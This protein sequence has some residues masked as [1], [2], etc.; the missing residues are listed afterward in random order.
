MPASNKQR[1]NGGT[2]ERAVLLGVLR[3]QTTREAAARAA[4]VTTDHLD[5]ARDALLAAQLPPASLTLKS[6]VERPVRIVRDGTG[7]PHIYAET[8]RDLFVGYGFALAQDRLWQIDYYRRRALGRLAEILGPSAVASD[9]RHRLLGLGRLAD[10]EIPTLSEEAATALDGFTAGINAW[11][12]HLTAIGSQLPVE[13]EIL[14]YTPEPWAVRDSIALMRAFFWQ[15][16]GRL[17]NIA[18]GEAANRFLG[19]DLGADFLTTEAADETI[20]PSGAGRLVGAGTGGA[21]TAGGSNNWAVSASRSASGS[22]MLA[23]D[24]HL[25]YM[26]PAGLYQVHLSGAGYDATGSGYPGTPGIWFGHNDRIAWG[27]TNL[28]ASPRD[29]YVE[30]LNPDD[31]TQYRDGD[32]WT[33]LAS[34]TETISVKDAAEETITIRETVRG[35]LVDEIVPLAPEAGPNGEPTALSV[36]WTGQEIVGDVQALLDMNRA[37]DWASFRAA[38]SGWRLPIFNLVYADVDGHIGWQATGSIPIRGT[39]DLSRGYRPA[40]DP[41]HAW[42]GYIPFDDLPRLEDPARGWVGTANNRPVAV[43]EQT[44]PL[45]GWWAPGHRAA[46]L[47]QLLDDGRTLSADDMRAMHADTGNGRAAEVLPKLP[48]LIGGGA[49]GAR[50]LGLLDGWSR[51]MSADSVAATVFEAFFEGWQR[52]VIAARL[53]AEVQP[54]L[55][56]LGAGSGLA[57][58][59]L[60]QGTPADWFGQS[61]S[62]AAVAEETAAQTLADL[63]A[64]FGADTAG[65]RWGAVHQVSFV[66]PLDGRP[67]TDGLFS[68]A[69]REVAGTGYVLNANS[70]S[71]DEP[72]DVVSG[73]EY[74]LVVDLGDLDATT[75]VLTT[76]QS[77]LPGSP[78]YAD[79]VDPWVRCE[80][81][82]LPFSPAAVEA[83]KAGETR[84][85]P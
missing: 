55:G 68:T 9:R 11:M 70:F 28:V 35:P 82:P 8:A 3:G 54:F 72:F 63:E 26:L 24:P 83:A 71:H 37:S 39:G 56:S 33:A 58:R 61:T 20:L 23:S 6:A 15:L 4:G 59:L 64:R 16:T 47:R 50:L 43:D 21:D 22:A 65:W 84:L 75:A 42:T 52:R 1:A 18:A 80:P 19:A 53:P 38:L 76:G 67:G 5:A 10:G 7:T 31:S 40:N 34:R 25:P 30:T 41:A 57:M 73:P 66:H 69:P 13:F 60:S 85:E 51:Q 12:S 14:E 78:H 29:L 79:M 62:I 74:R 2:V 32:T 81:L 36:R 27:I 44:V 45:Y 49:A 48:A 17:E 77:G 46:R